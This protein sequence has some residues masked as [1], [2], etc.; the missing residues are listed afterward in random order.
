MNIIAGCFRM[1]KVAQ[2]YEEEKIEY[3]NQAAIQKTREI[4]KNCLDN[5]V[6]IL[7]VMRATGLTRD[8]ISKLL[9]SS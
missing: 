6:D 3:G 8:E 4:A 2:L 9:K 5:G 1:T 7:T